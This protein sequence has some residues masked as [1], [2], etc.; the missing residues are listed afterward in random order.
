MINFDY[1]NLSVCFFLFGLRLFVCLFL[2]LSSFSFQIEV[3]K[4]IVRLLNTVDSQIIRRI[5]SFQVPSN[6]DF[7]NIVMRP[8]F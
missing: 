5:V 6:D 8:P 3:Q 7:G 1:L 4:K 2:C